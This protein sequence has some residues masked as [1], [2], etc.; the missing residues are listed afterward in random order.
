VTDWPSSSWKYRSKPYSKKMR[1]LLN[2]Y[3]HK[4]YVTKCPFLTYRMEN[5]FGVTNRI[6]SFFYTV[7]GIYTGHIVVRWWRQS[8]SNL[9]FFCLL[10]YISFLWRCSLNLGPGL[11]SWNSPFHFGLLL[12]RHSVGHL[13]QVISSSQVLCLYT[14]TEKRTYTKHPC[15][16]WDSN[17]R[18][19]LPSEW[20]QCMC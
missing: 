10:L 11:P 12:F 7:P 13:G 6:K 14:N 2:I 15:R 1:V 8:F 18:S 3:S 16:E 5:I 9:F 17:P 19:R 20:R 4:R